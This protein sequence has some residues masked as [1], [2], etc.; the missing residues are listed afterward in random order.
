MASKFTRRHYVAIA[1]VLNQQYTQHPSGDARHL[2]TL[3]YTI[4]SLVEMF[5]EDNP[6]FDYG[7]FMSAVKKGA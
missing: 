4:D 1:R 7:R 6:N 5:E 3:F 2:D